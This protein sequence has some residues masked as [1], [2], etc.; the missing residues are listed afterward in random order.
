MALPA[1]K[2]VATKTHEG[3][4]KEQPGIC[5]AAGFCHGSHGLTLL[6]LRYYPAKNK[7]LPEYIKGYLYRIVLKALRAILRQSM[8]MVWTKYLYVRSPPLGDL[9]RPSVH[10]RV[11][12]GLPFCILYFLCAFV[13]FRG[14]YQLP[15]A[16]LHL[17]ANTCS[18][19]GAYPL[20]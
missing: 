12:R 18:F 4:R 14:Q 20:N 9:G 3:T 17:V 16:I 7:R 15:Q 1:A 5:L 13:C 6:L 8:R 10:I 2:R 19:R 11:I